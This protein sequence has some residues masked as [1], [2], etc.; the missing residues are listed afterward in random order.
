MPQAYADANWPYDVGF[1]ILADGSLDLDWSLED[2]EGESFELH[3]A[4]KEYLNRSR[5]PVLQASRKFFHD[6]AY[7]AIDGLGTALD[8]A[9]LDFDHDDDDGPT[10]DEKHLNNIRKVKS[11]LVHKIRQ[12]VQREFQ[13]PASHH[14]IRNLIHDSGVH[15]VFTVYTPEKILALTNNETLLTARRRH[16]ERCGYINGWKRLENFELIIAKHQIRQRGLKIRNNQELLS[17]LLDEVRKKTSADALA[18]ASIQVQDLPDQIEPEATDRGESSH[19]KTRKKRGKRPEPGR[20]WKHLTISRDETSASGFLHERIIILFL[21]AN[22]FKS[23]PQAF[24]ATDIGETEGPEISEREQQTEPYPIFPRTNAGAAQTSF[25]QSL[26]GH[27]LFGMQS[28]NNSDLITQKQAMDI[29]GNGNSVVEVDED[30]SNSL[31]S[32]PE[33]DS[34]RYRRLNH[35][36]KS[37]ELENQRLKNIPTTY[38]NWKIIHFISPSFG[39]EPA[40]YFDRPVLAPGLKH[41]DF[42]LRAFLPITDV[43]SYV[44]QT[45]LDFVVSRFYSASSLQSEVRSAMAKKQPPP[46][47]R[48]YREH[49]QLQ[50]QQMVEALLEFLSLQPGFWDRFPGFDAGEPIDAPYILWY[51]YRSTDALQQLQPPQR[52]LMHMMTSWI[53]Q[54]YAKN[55]DE[56]ASYLEKGVVTLKTLPFLMCPGD[57]LIWKEKSKMKA[58]ITSSLLK[59]MSTPILYWDSSQ[60][61]W[62]ERNT[63]DGTKKGEFSTT[64]IAEAWNYEFIGDFYRKKVP[65]EIKFKAS[66]LEQ[67]VEISRLAVYPLRFAD[68]KTKLQ[69]ETRGRTFWSCRVRN[70]VSY[71]GE[72]GI[73]AVCAKFSG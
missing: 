62:S 32:T 12:T 69:L 39:Q 66:S 50:S 13:V 30:G 24:R 5:Q 6:F 16:Y 31:V 43:G 3:V 72:E 47:P 11:D 45:G 15:E 41:D 28:N 19:T 8:S 26:S 25:H 59:Q 18:S 22:L 56:A 48:P 71:T 35:R 1:S 52:D 14:I 53:E 27:A 55:Y 44:K 65:I 23:G 10:F 57:V 63:R 20:I 64:W 58:A 9:F 34:F 7:S 49:I 2:E 33:S 73:F 68:E 29:N 60:I 17:T 54:N 4:F 42:S 61:M 37:L 67:E 21:R 40:A 38:E 51:T 36:L 46:E 70:L